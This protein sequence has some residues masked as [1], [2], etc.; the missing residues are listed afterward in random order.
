MTNRTNRH[1]ITLIELLV[2]VLILAALSAIAIPRIA[3]SADNIKSNACVVNIDEINSSI[4]RFYAE[5][6]R[7][8]VNLPE[9]THDVDY[10]PRGA[11][12]CPVTNAEYPDSLTAEFRVD[13]SGHAH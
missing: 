10:F 12:K 5:N 2:V 6:D 4:E 7:Y 3:Q 11:P 8:P 13:D 9:L 1:G